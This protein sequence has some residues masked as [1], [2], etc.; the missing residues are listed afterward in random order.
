MQRPRITVIL[1]THGID[2]IFKNSK[3]ISFTINRLKKAEFY[4][5]RQKLKQSKEEQKSSK[6]SSCCLQVLLHSK[7]TDKAAKTH[8]IQLFSILQLTVSKNFSNN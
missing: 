6:P 7:S 1:K 8:S 4:Q 2:I 3:N 5:I